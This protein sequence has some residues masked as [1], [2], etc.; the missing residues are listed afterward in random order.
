ML[1][2]FL[3]V[4]ILNEIVLNVLYLPVTLTLVGRSVDN[5]LLIQL[6]IVLGCTGEHELDV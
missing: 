1:N 6:G 3:I 4:L 5:L 2:L